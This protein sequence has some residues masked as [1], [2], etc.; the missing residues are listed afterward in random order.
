MG[1]D[2]L[3][4]AVWFL[5]A[6][7]VDLAAVSAVGEYESVAFFGAFDE[8]FES[9]YDVVS[10]GVSVGEYSHVEWGGWDESEAVEGVCYVFC[11]VDAAVE[12]WSSGSD[13]V[14]VVYAYDEGS[15]FLSEDIEEADVYGLWLCDGYG[16]LGYHYFWFFYLLLHVT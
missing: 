7:V 14:V 16:W 13:G 11:V 8:P 15:A 2:G 3:V 4:F 9:C 1:A 5:A 6:G 10:C 12:V